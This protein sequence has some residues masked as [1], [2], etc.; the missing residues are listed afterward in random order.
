MPQSF[1]QKQ[2][3]HFHDPNLILNLIIILKAPG[4]YERISLGAVLKKSGKKVVTELPDSKR[5]QRIELPN[6]PS[7]GEV[8]GLA[9]DSDH[10]CVLHFE[11][12]VTRG[13]GRIIPLGSIQK[14]MRESIEA[15]TQYIRAKH[16]ELGITAEW[17]KN[18]DIAVLATYMGVPKEGPSAGITIVTG[19]VSALKKIP[20]R[21]DIAMTGEITIMGKILP[22]GGIHQKIQA[23]YE[24]GVKEIILPVDN[25]KEANGMPSYI[26]DSIKL[27]TVN[28]IKEVIELSLDTTI[29]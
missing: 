24:A 20:V 23:A 9:V 25:L 8:I 7:V 19:I 29:E 5:V 14:V 10:G 16:E 17:R 22:V 6:K 11:M 15:A 27:T 28:S 21:N 26:L 13:S 3:L 18:F 2:D 4:E 1:F 12:Q